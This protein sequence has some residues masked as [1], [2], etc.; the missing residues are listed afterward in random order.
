MEGRAA[1]P[2]AAPRAGRWGQPA[3][4][5]HQRHHPG[6][7]RGPLKP[8]SDVLALSALD[9]RRPREPAEVAGIEL[10]GVPFDGYGRPGNQAAAPQVLREAGIAAAVS[11]HAGHDVHEIG[12][13]ALPAGSP[14]RG[15]ATSLMNEQAL[16]A[17]V[18]AARGSC[19]RWRRPR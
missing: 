10:I 4:A 9:D 14:R 3:Q 8:H 7:P 15:A 17:M 16:V 6:P 5:R 11:G 13:L 18:D 1:A 2:L 12:D 19:G